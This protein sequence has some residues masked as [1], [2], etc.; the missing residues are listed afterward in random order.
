MYSKE[1]LINAVE[2][3]KSTLSTEIETIKAEGFTSAEKAEL[4][5]A[6]KIDISV[7]LKEISNSLKEVKK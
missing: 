6:I 5:N 2:D 7:L 3:F 1:N 4:R